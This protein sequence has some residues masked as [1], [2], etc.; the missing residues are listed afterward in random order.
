MPPLDFYDPKQ[1]IV[2]GI[3]L[4]LLMLLVYFML[5][6]LL[7]V[8]ATGADYRMRA[9]L[10]DETA[11]RAESAEASGEQPT[12]A[13]AGAN[14]RTPAAAERDQAAQTVSALIASGFVFL[15]LNG[16]PMSGGAQLPASGA[17][18]EDPASAAAADKDKRWAVQAASFR[19]KERAEK[20]AKQLKD[21][22]MEAVVTKT[23]NKNNE[24]W[25]VVRLPTQPTRRAAD[26]Q[27]TQ[28]RQKTGKKGIIVPVN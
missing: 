13:T 18:A 26:Q 28:L 9:P 17:A 10:P 19:Q 25:F 27:L 12:T 1:R 23:V 22:G 24:E 15:D 14:P 16:K 20:F 21:K 6:L 3:V 4:F 8:S 7:G 2:G 11:A 5:K